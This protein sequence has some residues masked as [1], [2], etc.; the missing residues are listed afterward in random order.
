MEYQSAIDDTILQILARK[1]EIRSNDLARTLTKEL[2]RTVYPDTFKTHIR[3]LEDKKLVHRKQEGYRGKVTYQLTHKAQL[4]M[5]Y[6]LTGTP[7]QNR[8]RQFYVACLLA[9]VQGPFKWGEEQRELPGFSVDEILELVNDS[10]FGMPHS[11]LKYDKRQVEETITTMEAEGLVRKIGV[12]DGTIRYQITN[13]EL[14]EFL[15]DVWTLLSTQYYVT[16]DL[17]W[18]QLHRKTKEEMEWIGRVWGEKVLAKELAKELANDKDIPKMPPAQVQEEL[19]N[20][21][22]WIAKYQEKI[23]RKRD[24][25]S[26]IIPIEVTERLFLQPV[27]DTRNRI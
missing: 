24:K 9:Q 4:E 14:Q 27:I 18:K 25:I 23:A 15:E 11:Y 21:D 6:R 19:K 20:G 1:R 10:F 26:K 22:A 2:G 7:K 13:E 16:I 3:R 17:K 12:I 5:L 8:N